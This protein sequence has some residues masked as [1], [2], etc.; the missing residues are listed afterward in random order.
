VRFAE[1]A[2]GVGIT[3][4]REGGDVTGSEVKSKEQEK[5]ILYNNYRIVVV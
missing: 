2:G 3:A 1:A 4:P 5:D